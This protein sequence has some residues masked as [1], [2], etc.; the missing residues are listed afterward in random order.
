MPSLFT[1]RESLVNSHRAL[2]ASLLVVA[3]VTGCARKDSESEHPAAGPATSASDAPSVAP[4]GKVVVVELNSDAKGN[5]F[6]P[7]DFEVHPGDVIRFTLKS[8]V[9]NVHFL[10]DSNPGKSNLPP[11]SDML[12]LPDQTLDIPVNFAKGHYYFQC[13][14]HVALGMKGHVEVE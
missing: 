3:A 4:T 8:G 6:K 13:D 11:A 12:Q 14:P 7:N 10:A 9:H 5:Y 1:T 2:I